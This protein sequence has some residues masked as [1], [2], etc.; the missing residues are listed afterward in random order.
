MREASPIW[1]SSWI[2]LIIII[3]PLAVRVIRAPK[4]IQ[5]GMV[6]WFHHMVS[7]GQGTTW[8]SPSLSRLNMWL[9]SSL[10]NPSAHL[11]LIFELRRYPRSNAVLT[12]VISSIT[13][14]LMKGWSVLFLPVQVQRTCPLPTNKIYCIERE[15]ERKKKAKSLEQSTTKLKITR[16][17]MKYV[18]EKLISLS[19]ED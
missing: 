9:L 17:G 1:F 7:H 3:Y 15:R 4:M 13:G 19:A 11:A 10:W 16:Y 6:A 8:R 14:R 5:Y 2:Y 18:R 12:P